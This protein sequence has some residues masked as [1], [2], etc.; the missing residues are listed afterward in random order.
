VN[1]LSELGPVQQASA[2]R[3]TAAT[4]AVILDEHRGL[5]LIVWTVG[6]TGASLVG[7]VNAIRPAAAARAAFDAWCAALAVTERVYTASSLGGVQ[8]WAS[9]DAGRVRVSITAAMFGDDQDEAQW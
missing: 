4:L 9:V 3:R 7:H 5:P 1:G 2:Q 8:L 6:T